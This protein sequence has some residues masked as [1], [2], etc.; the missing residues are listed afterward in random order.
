MAKQFLTAA[1]RKELIAKNPFADLKAAVIAEPARMHFI[2][3][4]VAEQVIAACPDAQWRLLFVLSRYGGLRCPSEH[5]ALRWE[6]INWEKNVILIHSPKTEHHPGG[7]TR[8]IPLFPELRPYLLEV[9][10]EAEPGTEYVITRY[11]M[12]NPNLRT[13]LLR[14]IKR[15]GHEKWPKL[16]QNLRSSRETELSEDYPMHVV[17][18]WMGNSQ[19]VAAKHYLQVTNEHFARG[20]ADVGHTP[21]AGAE[22]GDQR[23]DLQPGPDDAHTAEHSETSAN[24]ELPENA[25]GQGDINPEN[26][27]QNAMQKASVGA[28]T[29]SHA[30]TG[31][32]RNARTHVEMQN[33]ATPCESTASGGVGDAGLEPATS[34]V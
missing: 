24:D 15:A 14:I 5:L 34:R 20:A 16:F 18:K 27:V 3:R 4:D 30:E 28:R 1:V 29:V 33:K 13:H 2:T 17:C 11:R 6:D 7:D 23:N 8:L 9:F 12:G 22:G 21:A 19:P 25:D 31:Q 10:A 26:P 32:S